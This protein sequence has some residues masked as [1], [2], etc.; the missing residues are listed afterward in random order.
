MGRRVR[1][2]LGALVG[3]VVL[4]AA[5]LGFVGALAT[6]AEA[7]TSGAI[8]GYQGLCLDDFAGSSADGT[9]VDLYGCN[10]TPAQQWTVASNN[11]LQINGKC[12]DITG[13]STADGALVELWD[14]N[15]GGN[16]VWQQGANNTL[17]NPASG[18]CLDDPG[19]STANGT[20]LDIWDCNNGANQQWNLPGGSTP[21]SG[22]LFSPY[23]D[24]TINMNWNTYQMQSAA[25][26]SVL[27]VVGSG[28]L[29]SQYIPKLPALTLAFATGSCGS[30]TWGGVSGANFA[31]E[32]VPQL[33]AA[34]LNYVVSTGG[35][36]G[37]FTCTSTAGM[38]SFI[39]RYAS[40]NLVGIDFDIEG[41]QS[42]SDIS[43]LVAAA[44]GAQSQYPN[45]QFSFTLATLGASD[46]SYG[47]V[48]SL[49]N[50]VVQAVRGSSL[51]KYVINLMTMDFGNASSSVCVV[52]SG[53]CEMAQ[54]SIQAVQNLEHTYGIPA[55][56]IAVTPMIGMNDAT[57][58]TFTAADVNTLSSYA[59]SNGLAGLH[60][61]S[62]D[63][64]TPCSDSYASPTCNSLSSTTPLEYTDKFLSALGD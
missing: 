45:L 24:V 61:W 34:N 15:G 49:G 59:V 8:T 1:R 42:E 48:N 7:A 9:I 6:T 17:V 36:A 22:L 62:L 35:A 10:N 19:F 40:P 47:G 33:H 18:K 37:T 13:A 28:S 11:T 53:S 27:P 52:S 29:V 5:T 43:N 46:G 16:Q 44:A 3:A 60:F 4:V 21:V 25:S 54:S 56:K 50:E 30:E 58:E 20:Q 2:R 31:A 57:S 63:R 55:S 38:E 64:D 26:G 41:G 51:S 12:L 39:A 23:K 14:C 32:N